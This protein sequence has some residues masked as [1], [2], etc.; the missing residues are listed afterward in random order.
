M[1]AGAMRKALKRALRKSKDG[2]GDEGG[3]GE[4]GD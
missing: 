3:E 2:E 1:W 4:A